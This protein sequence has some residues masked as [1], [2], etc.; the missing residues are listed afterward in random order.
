MEHS[1]S[2][3][4]EMRL[5]GDDRVQAEVWFSYRWGWEWQVRHFDDA[6]GWAV[7]DSGVCKSPQRALISVSEAL[8]EV[9]HT[10]S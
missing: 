3:F 4:T 8:I 10:F 9:A 1:S 5:W 7:V 2:R 6:Q